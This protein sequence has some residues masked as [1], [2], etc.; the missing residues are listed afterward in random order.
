MQKMFDYTNF[1]VLCSIPAW[2]HFIQVTWEPSDWIKK[3]NWHRCLNFCEHVL[4]VAHAQVF[5]NL[6]YYLPYL[7]VHHQYQQRLLDKYKDKD[8]AFKCQ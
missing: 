6:N 2:L 8:K 3:C 7:H 5:I 1:Q 4:D